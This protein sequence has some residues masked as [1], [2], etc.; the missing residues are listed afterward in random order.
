MKKVHVSSCLLLFVAVVAS[1][2]MGDTLYMTASDGNGESSFTTWKVSGGG[3][4][5]PTAANEYIDEGYNLRA[6]SQYDAVFN[7]KSLTLGSYANDKNGVLI[8]YNRATQKITFANDGLFAEQGRL[9]AWSGAHEYTYS[10]TITVKSPLGCPF[11]IEIA[12]AASHLA[13]TN[14]L[15]ATFKGEADTELAIVNNVA[16]PDGYAILLPAADSSFAGTLTLGKVDYGRNQRLYPVRVEY[17]NQ[18]TWP[19]TIHVKGESEL[20]PRYSSAKWTLGKLVLDSGSTLHTKLAGEDTSTITLVNS[21][22]TEYPVSLTTPSSRTSTSS[23]LKSTVWSVLTL[24]T[25]KGDLGDNV[26]DFVLATQPSLFPDSLPAVFLRVSTNEAK[27]VAS[28]DLVQRQIVRLTA[29]NPLSAWRATGFETAVT[30][31]ASWSDGAVPHADADYVVDSADVKSLCLPPQELVEEG[32]RYEFPGASITLGS[33]G[34]VNL[35]AAAATTRI[36]V[37]R[38]H[39]DARF[40]PSCFDGSAPVVLEGDAIHLLATGGGTSYF[41]IYGNRI[42]TVKA[43]LSGAGR[44]TV[45]N[46]SSSGNPRATIVFDADNT[47]FTGRIRLAAAAKDGVYNT[48]LVQ[49]GSDVGGALDSFAHDALELCNGSVLAVTNDVALS[50]ENRGVAVGAGGAVVDVADGATLSLANPVT[51]AAGAALAKKGAGTLALGGAMLAPGGAAPLAGSG[52]AGSL[53]VEEGFLQ[54]LAT[55][56]VDGVSVSFAG[57]AYLLVDMEAAGDVAKFGAVDMSDAPFG[58]SLPV[59]FDLP[60]LPAS[61]EYDFENIAVATVKSASVARSLAVSNRRIRRHSVKFSIR[62]NADGSATILASIKSKGFVLLF[63]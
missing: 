48:L 26:G 57:G 10:G 20:I 17:R 55:N 51:F 44:L 14:V 58:G 54:A 21:L 9:T 15:A 35:Y 5:A 22:V 18:I 42:Y 33:Q 7:G 31:A 29:N 36:P 24:P 2:A 39:A 28:L 50:A 59:A 32:G 37:L 52:S 27:T 49:K 38:M 13:N 60:A 8:G 40:W 63:L 19:G 43:P 34:N 45:F 25:D 47:A 4:S 41:R 6:P 23:T 11:C 62:E 30:N 3:T 53:S 16:N 1:S 12:D 61:G 46:N 56:A